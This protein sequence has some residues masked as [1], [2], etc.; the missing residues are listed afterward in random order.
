MLVQ[1]QVPAHFAKCQR[2]RC[3]S[4]TFGGL[5]FQERAMQELPD[6]LVPALDQSHALAHRLRA[7]PR[8]LHLCDMRR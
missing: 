7:A 4:A 2:S 1:P 6:T 3:F 5:H 8:S